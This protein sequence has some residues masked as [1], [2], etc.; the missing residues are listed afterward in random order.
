MAA[1]WDHRRGRD[2]RELMA[3]LDRAARAKGERRE[4]AIA[5]LQEF[6][7]VNATATG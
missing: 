1:L 4:A 3:L 2:V 6:E 5:M 7:N